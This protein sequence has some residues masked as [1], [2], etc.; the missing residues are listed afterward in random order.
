MIVRLILLH[1]N[2]LLMKSFIL[3]AMVLVTIAN[4]LFACQQIEEPDQFIPVM[5]EASAELPK[6]WKPT[7][8]SLTPKEIQA[9]QLAGFAEHGV[10]ILQGENSVAAKHAFLIGGDM[11]AS[12]DNIQE[13]AELTLNSPSGAKQYRYGVTV[14]PRYPT[15]RVRGVNMTGNPELV[16]ALR[17]AVASY[18]ALNL[19]HTLQLSFVRTGRGVPGVITNSNVISV[20]PVASLEVEGAAAL[21]NLPTIFGSPGHTIR[22]MN[23]LART[24]ATQNFI[25]HLMMHEI[26]H[27]LGMQHT[28]W[29]DPMANSCSRGNTNIPILGGGTAPTV[30]PSQV[31]SVHIPGTPQRPNVDAISIFR[32]CHPGNFA[33]INFSQFDQIALETIF[34]VNPIIITP[35]DG[36]VPGRNTGCPCSPLERCLNGSCVPL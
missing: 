2:I 7:D 35:G 16:D 17:H 26:G 8:Q 12:W 32:T 36:G 25:R 10:E 1:L 19:R 21:A 9:L 11:I 14:G 22:V 4:L 34:P 23:D 20:I 28:D 5:Q 3:S 6:Y 27:T 18:N 33:Q 13:R 29:F 30:E 24:G 15:I 31:P